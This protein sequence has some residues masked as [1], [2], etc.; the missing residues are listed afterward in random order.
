MGEIDVLGKISL[1]KNFLVINLS[2]YLNILLYEG[3]PSNLWETTS[4]GFPHAP[5]GFLPD[6]LFQSTPRAASAGANK[7]KKFAPRI[8]LKYWGRLS[9]R[10]PY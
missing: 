10:K 5:S 4:W 2:R 8:P 9:Y 1:A 3:V 7:R 6:P